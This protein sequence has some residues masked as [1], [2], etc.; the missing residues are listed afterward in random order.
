MPKCLLTL[1]AFC[2]LI[3]QAQTTTPLRY[4][5]CQAAMATVRHTPLSEATLP[6]P[7]TAQAD[8]IYTIDLLIAYDP[9]GVEVADQQG[10]VA[11]H[12]ARIITICNEVM[13]NSHINA[14]FRLAGTTEIAEV[15]GSISS[16]LGQGM[17][18][19]QI[20]AERRAKRADIVVLCSEP[21]NDGL[22]GVAVLEAP[23][24]AMA[25]ASVRASSATANYTVIHEI[26]HIFGCQHSREA[27]D[28]GTHP[29]AVGASRAPY[30]TVMG[31]PEQEGLVEQVPLFS[32]PESV[33]QGVVMG[34]DTENAVRK[35]RERV[36][37]V[38]AF[39]QLPS[40]T[41]SRTQWDIDHA[42][43]ST[44]ITLT[45][46]TYYDIRSSATW[47][48]PSITGGYGNTTFTLSA[49]ANPTAENRTATLTIEGD[50]AY[51]PTTI[52][53]T[54]QGQSTSI[55]QV[56]GTAQQVEWQ[57]GT[58]V[59]RASAATQM[60]IYD[61]QGRL[62]HQQQLGI[63]THRLPRE[64]RGL[65]IIRLTTGQQTLTYRLH[66]E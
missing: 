13:T 52:T 16:A 57:A 62:L 59:V 66:A 18:H 39:D 61:T 17:S 10:G 19:A 51:Q 50:D 56:A 9:K 4:G 14:R 26:G 46:S 58:L 41:I 27:L 2:T 28:A 53:V 33:W 64:E 6:T 30:Y 47:L 29:Y 1:F 20:S 32:G 21:F 8:T 31:F 37:Q 3:I 49:E 40:Y 24:G 34:S 48:R 11:V 55:K 15:M 22:E 42:A 23:R 54:Q 44:D 7:T 60:A 36:A 65:L 5:T 43:Q 35:I 38:A 25:Y 63:G 45:T 12:A